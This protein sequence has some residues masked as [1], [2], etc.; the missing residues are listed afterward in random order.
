MPGK[1]QL[2]CGDLQRGI[3]AG[4]KFIDAVSVNIEAD[5]WP[6]FSKLSSEREPYI[7]EANNGEPGVC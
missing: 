6:F 7:A 4:F 1:A 2:L 5:D 3:R